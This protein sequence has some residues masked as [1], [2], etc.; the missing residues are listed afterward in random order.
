MKTRQA[1]FPTPSFPAPGLA[2]AQPPL[3]Q[4]PRGGLEQ[5]ASRRVGS[6]ARELSGPG[7]D[8]GAIEYASWLRRLRQ[9]A[10]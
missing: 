6:P 10:P 2:T 8:P 1:T 3:R 9:R 4:A 5:V 7:S